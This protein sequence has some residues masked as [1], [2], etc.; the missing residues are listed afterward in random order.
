MQKISTVRTNGNRIFKGRKL[1]IGLDLGDRSSYYCVLD[2]MGEVILERKL[3]TTPK[4]LEEAFGRMPQSRMALETG[5]HSPWVKRNERP[6][7]RR[8]LGLP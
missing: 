6:C 2:D 5:A 1:T 4:A 3:S 7:A 8:R